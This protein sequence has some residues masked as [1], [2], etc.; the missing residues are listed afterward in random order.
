MDMAGNISEWVS[1][2]F[3]RYHKLGNL[4]GGFWRGGDGACRLA[5]R[6]ASD[7]DEP[8]P[9]AGFRLAMDLLG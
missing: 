5:G 6:F 3:D 4:K 9:F 7:P 1:D 8:A 2:S